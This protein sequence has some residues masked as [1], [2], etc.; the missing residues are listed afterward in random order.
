MNN[1]DPVIAVVLLNLIFP[2]IKL[3]AINFPQYLT[4]TLVQHFMIFFHQIILFL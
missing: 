3:L 2:D 1:I 4:Q